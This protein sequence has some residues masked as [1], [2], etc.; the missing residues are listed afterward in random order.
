MSDFEADL[1]LDFDLGEMELM[2]DPEMAQLLEEEAREAAEERK[3]QQE[4]QER[5]DKKRKLMEQVKKRQA[6]QRRKEE[7]ERRREM[8]RKAAEEA[9][10]QEERN[11]EKEEEFERRKR[12]ALA[13]HA[14]A[15]KN[16]RVAAAAADMRAKAGTIPSNKG[17]ASPAQPQSSKP[18]GN[19]SFSSP[20][21]ELGGR[22]FAIQGTFLAM[23]MFANTKVEEG[24]LCD[25][26]EAW[27]E[28]LRA[29]CGL[30]PAPVP[31]DLTKEAETG[32]ATSLFP[33]LQSS[34]KRPFFGLG[35]VNSK[36][37]SGSKERRD[38][39]IL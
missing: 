14:E 34:R 5:E 39:D 3:R 38:E 36:R 37:P 26:V 2:D 17:A 7:E 11:K 6:D 13:A 32:K 33:N 4:K 31:V 20:Q 16:K 25:E 8:D 30:P 27:T 22:R 12:D 29:I 19:E 21:P 9:R 23:L 24:L 15:V 35:P 28:R 18:F 10:Q 1:D